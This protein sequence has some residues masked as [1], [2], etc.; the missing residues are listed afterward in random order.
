[1]EHDWH[2]NDTATKIM[3]SIINLLFLS[4]N[5]KHPVVVIIYDSGYWYFFSYS[6]P[7][8]SSIWLLLG[9]ADPG[10]FQIL[11]VVSFGVWS[12][13]TI[14]TTFL[15]NRCWIW[16]FLLSFIQWRVF[17]C[18]SEMLLVSFDRHYILA[19]A[20]PTSASPSSLNTIN[21][22]GKVKKYLPPPNRLFYVT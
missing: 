21:I 7:Q 11:L 12:V 22:R 9:W 17:N 16:R 18:L 2:P 10:F 14:V 15:S 13:V 5:Y 19:L 20:L 1:M 6:V 8:T 4:I 3:M